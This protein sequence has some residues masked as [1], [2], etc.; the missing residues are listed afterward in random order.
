MSSKTFSALLKIVI[1]GVALC[2][3]F[4][5]IFLVPEFGQSLAEAGDGEF[6]YL[7]NPWLIVIELTALPIAAALVLAWFIAVNI[8]RDRGFC[9]QNAKL[10]AVISILAIVD[11]A[12]FFAACIALMFI[13]KVG[14]PSVLIFM[15]LACFVGVAIAVAAAALSHYA[16]KGAE[17]QE[18]SDLTI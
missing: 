11:V 8:G 3:A 5:Y 10:L 13:Y 6:A 7:Y 18:Q 12:Y 14:H 4:V 16:R 17:L 15:L 9:I 2:A 1:I